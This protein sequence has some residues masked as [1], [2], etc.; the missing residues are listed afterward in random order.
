MNTN[1]ALELGA[2]S[3]AE[4]NRL[5]VELQC[6]ACRQALGRVVQGQVT[7]HGCGFKIMEAGGIHR[8]LADDRVLYFRR[9]MREYQSIRQKEG[10]GSGS[11]EYYLALPFRDITENNSWQW[12]IRARTFLYF[13]QNILPKIAA[14]KPNGADILDIGAGNG[15][16]SYRLALKKHYPIAMDLA[17]DSGDGLGAAQHYFSQPIEAFPRFQAEMDRLPFARR[18]FDAV[19]FNASFHYSTDYEVTLRE[20][21]RCLRHP[22][23]LVI[24]D[25]PLYRR[26][27][28]GERM[29]AERK[30]D[31]CR[32]FGF[33]SDSVPSKEYLTPEVLSDL[34][35]RLSLE[36]NIAKPW[37]GLS[38]ALRPLRAWILGRREPSKFYL[39]WVRV[40]R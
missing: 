40:E 29:S 15:W 20:A 12:K 18:Q 33:A 39:L 5:R 34:A 38:W 22:G 17:D 2:A 7:C 21:L 30:A 24:A 27:E 19:V 16:L 8:A 10:R 35:R 23:Y 32:R 14:Q 36:W 11:P 31:F 13:E 25:S 4:A 1:A 28:S 6:P 37:Y 3:S 26:A 9:F